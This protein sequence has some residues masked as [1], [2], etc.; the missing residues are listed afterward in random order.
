[1]ADQSIDLGAVNRQSEMAVSIYKFITHLATKSF[2]DSQFLSPDDPFA[3]VLA[4]E[5][6]LDDLES[7]DGGLNTTRID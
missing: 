2:R 6:E 5:S 3:F 1:M 4:T 7:I